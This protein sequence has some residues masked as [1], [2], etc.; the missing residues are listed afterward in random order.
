MSLTVGEHD[1]M[2]KDVMG[3]QVP[4]IREHLKGLRITLNVYTAMNAMKELN[5]LEILD[6]EEYATELT[7]SL[8]EVGITEKS[9]DDLM[10]RI[11]QKYSKKEGES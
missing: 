7:K 3:Y 1:S 5:R 6:D 4:N 2:W 8:R 10:K 11:E 9:Y